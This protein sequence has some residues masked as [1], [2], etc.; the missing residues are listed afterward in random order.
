MATYC[1][2]YCI[3]NLIFLNVTLRNIFFLHQHSYGNPQKII[4]LLIKKTQ[5][6]FDILEIIVNIVLRMKVLSTY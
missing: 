1:N 3:R 6:F 4:Y 2:V 5:F